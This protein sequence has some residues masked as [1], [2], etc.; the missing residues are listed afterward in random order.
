MNIDLLDVELE[1]V[2]GFKEAVEQERELTDGELLHI[3]AFRAIQALR[4]WKRE[5]EEKK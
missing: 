2:K 4:L 5:Q 3:N 1:L